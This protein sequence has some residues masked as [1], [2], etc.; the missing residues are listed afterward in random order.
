[1]GNL[2]LATTSCIGMGVVEEELASAAAAAA[3][4]AGGTK[5]KVVTVLKQDGTVLELAQEVRVSKLLKDYPGHF[6]CKS[7]ELG[8]GGKA[9]ILGPNILLQ[10]G[11]VY[12][13]LSQNQASMR[14]C[15][16]RRSKINPL[17]PPAESGPQ[18]PDPPRVEASSD[19]PKRCQ[20]IRLV[21]SKQQ[22]A[23]MIAGGSMLISAAASSSCKA[24]S[25]PL[26]LSSRVS[27]A[28]GFSYSSMRLFNHPVATNKS[29]ARPKRSWCP[30]L[31]SIVEVPSQ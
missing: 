20:R 27:R 3:G 4:T 9:R 18:S 26:S 13:V 31:D 10:R 17:V 1:M 12:L 2:A 23:K 29:C 5:K 11:E 16:S 21:M 24:V 7:E 28:A 8:S 6:V 15:G 22:L 14:R 19:S 25:N 30:H